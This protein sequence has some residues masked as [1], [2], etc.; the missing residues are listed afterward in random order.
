MPEIKNLFLQGKMNKDLDER[1]IP[2]GQYRH[3]NNIS[4]SYSEGADVGVVQNI[5]G[6]TEIS[7]GLTFPAG[8]S[9][10]GTVRDTENNK[11]YWFGTSPTA[12]Y[13]AELD[14]SNNS[15]DIILCEA[16]TAKLTASSNAH[17]AGSLVIEMAQT[18]GIISEQYVT[19]ENIV[20]G[21]KVDTINS[22]TLVLSQAPSAQIQNGATLSFSNI[23]KF[24]AARYITGINI[25]DGILYY[26]DNFTE[27]KQIDIDYWKSQTTNFST[28]TTNLSEDRIT[29]IKKS[30]LNAPTFDTLSASVRSGVGTL[31][32]AIEIITSTI[33][34]LYTTNVNDSITVVFS[35]APN[36]LAND[37]IILDRNIQV[38]N[39]TTSSAARLKITSVT[40]TTTFV[41]T[42]LAKTDNVENLINADYVPLLE[43]EEPLFEL[44]FPRFSYRY[45][46]KNAQYSTFAPFSVPAFLPNTFE[47]NGKKAYN[48]GMENQIR[49]LK[50]KGWANEENIGTI[51]N[52]ELTPSADNYAVDIE[53]IDILYK[54]SVSANIYVVD[55]IKK[56]NGK[57]ATIFEIKDEQIFKTIPANQL[58]RT[59]DS[60]PKKALGQEIVGNR[61]I[62]SNITENF[63]YNSRPNFTINTAPRTN[64]I[65]LSQKFSLKTKRTYQL[66]VTFKDKYGRETPVFSDKSGVL[67]LSQDNS[68]FNLQFEVST[69]TTPP[70]EATHYKYYIKETSNE[71]YNLCV[72]NVYDD[73]E[74]F[75]YIAAPS[76]EVNKVSAEDFI[77]LKKQTGNVAYHGSEKR[78][79]VIDKLS[80]PPDFLAKPKK[81]TYAATVFIFDEQ[82]ETNDSLEH[83]QA[84]KT[85]VEGYNTIILQD[86]G[87]PG[88]SA[89]QS[90]ITDKFRSEMIVGTEVRFK[91]AGTG[92]STKPYIIKSVQYTLNTTGENAG[93][94]FTFEPAFGEDVNI[95]YGDNKFNSPLTR[96]E[97]YMEKI[98]TSDDSGNAEYEGKFFLKVDNNIELKEAIEVAFDES[99][100][101]TLGTQV[102]KYNVDDSDERDYVLHQINYTQGG[103]S[104]GSFNSISYNSGFHLIL[105]SGEYWEDSG[106]FYTSNPFT[107]GFVKGNFIRVSG[108]DQNKETGDEISDANCLYE[109]I[110]T[111]VSSTTNSKNITVTSATG[112][113][114]GDEV[115]GNGGFTQTEFVKVTAVLGTLITLSS[116]QSV[117]SG[118]S[119][120]FR[121]AIENHPNY[122]IEEVQL[123]PG[124]G[125]Q[126]G[127]YLLKLDRP[128][129]VQLQFAPGAASGAGQNNRYSF[130]LE[131]RSFDPKIAQTKTTNPVIF[132]IEPKEGPL[133]IYYET[134]ETYPIADLT[135]P[136][137]IP[138]SNCISFGNG[139][140]SER[141]RDDYNAPRIT[142]GVRVS[143]VI[144][145]SYQEDHL[146]SRLI[147][148]GIYNSKTNLNRL[149]EFIIAEPIT[150]DLNPEYGSIQK[151]HARDTDLIALCEDRIVKILANKD[152]LFN[153]DGNPQ[154]TAT[155]RVLGQAI[156]PATFGAYGISKNPESFVDFTYRAY[157]TDKSRGKVLRLSMDGLTEISEYGM[158][159]YFKDTLAAET[160]LVL[161]TYDEN[162]GQYNITFENQAET[163]SFS[164]GVKGWPSFKSFIPESGISLNNVY[165]T[166]KNGKL[167]SHTNSSRNRFYDAGTASSLIRFVLNDSP[168]NIK[169]FRTL[170]Y[171]GSEGWIVNSILTDQQDGF[172]LSFVEKENVYYNYISAL[173]ESAGS[174]DTKAL[175]V[176]GLGD[177]GS[178]SLNG[179]VRTF[180][181][182]FEL[183]NGIAV[184]DDLYYLNGSNKVKLGTITEVN[185][186]AKTVKV[187]PS[188]AIP[189]A[190]NY[191]FYA[192]DA[193]FNTSGILGYYAEV[194]MSVT[195]TGAKELYTVGS[196]ISLS[197]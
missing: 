149:N 37:I 139:V 188:A 16:K 31:G 150:K 51:S 174:I 50:L 103:L 55:T 110:T 105:Q 3:A 17:T 177:L 115:T 49:V 8:A 71:Y 68:A 41:C 73:E 102:I 39:L 78:F 93:G 100:L 82:F 58:L 91:R 189:A 89:V 87:A 157:F 192:K 121:K 72:T 67:K 63:D 84:G 40:N 54:D 74:G 124:V 194:T 34:N 64:T 96:S 94:E 48:L 44:K 135:S 122:K 27:P 138:W 23:L 169:N 97:I 60:V 85:P 171:H 143:A 130:F 107:A 159:D 147:F 166:F 109:N 129:E 144:E 137:K 155:N 79:K 148:S 77:I 62:Y 52:D 183:P 19:G 13:I 53:E 11:I 111:T 92:K 28:N 128:F 101:N 151:L 47:Y 95:L 134:Q 164:E 22:T 10:I 146:K 168:A 15:V 30:P 175:N 7:S 5:L 163:V 59:F 170:N 98:E 126:F 33:P 45:K 133:E 65:E 42:L 119:L 35:V 86:A 56:E 152:A 116:A 46:Y 195:N 176:Q 191:M 145:E 184:P 154:L 112:I 29:V 132:E 167:Y 117:L 172:I 24:D 20:P 66:G 161:G 80:N 76:A 162:T 123:I 136:K 108:G 178:T 158:K 99:L 131:S 90:R 26:T 125:A 153:A 75:L 2:R 81:A 140:E 187:D 70:S 4:V 127:Y 190:G 113:E 88:E 180:G 57:F 9:C 104:N 21:T 185:R 142:N 173:T 61:L 83:K 120:R 12:D 18:G 1:L 181:F 118:T 186:T 6:N 141:I 14:S 160:G 38:G 114:I 36:Y 43:E 179:S 106:S 25:L 69:S 193:K 182:N 165:Y 156:I 197:S 196:E 32:N